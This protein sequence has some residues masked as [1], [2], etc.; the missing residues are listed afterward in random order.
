[1]SVDRSKLLNAVA[2]GFID[3]DGRADAIE[4]LRAA[5][6]AASRAGASGVYLPGAGANKRGYRYKGRA[7]H[8][9]PDLGL[10]VPAGMTLAG[11]G[12]ATTLVCDPSTFD[13]SPVPWPTH[14]CLFVD[15]RATVE[16]IAFEGPRGAVAGGAE[17]TFTGSFIQAA[18]DDVSDVTLTRI[19]CTGNV[20][21]LTE[22]FC[23]ATGLQSRRWT[24]RQVRCLKNNG[25]GISLNG[26]MVKERHAPGTGLTRDH[27]VIDCAGSENT[28]QGLTAYGCEASRIVRFEGWGNGS[29]KRAAGNGVNLEWCYRVTVEAPHCWGNVGGGVGGY[30]DNDDLLVLDPVL[31]GNDGAGHGG[32]VAFGPAAWWTGDP[33]GLLRG[34]TIRGGTIAPRSG[35]WH[36]HVN[37]RSCGAVTYPRP[38]PPSVPRVVAR[39][40][41]GLTSVDAWRTSG[42][43]DRSGLSVS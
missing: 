25:S 34:L 5:F 1:M 6:A 21:G 17:T 35:G 4:A 16:D 43:T 24:F 28:W 8:G 42:A 10:R 7:L 9:H 11:D 26:D 36:L 22:S 19:L 2:L 27:A 40:V 41:S 29:A 12:K 15:A 32:E 38:G 13:G 3:Q 18:R 39:G 31:S 20:G 14:G 23:V 30:G 37:K 33:K